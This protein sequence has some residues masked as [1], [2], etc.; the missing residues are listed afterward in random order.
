MS[1]GSPRTVLSPDGTFQTGQTDAVGRF[2]VAC[3]S[4]YESRS[5]FLPGEAVDFVPPNCYHKGSMKA[6][7]WCGGAAFQE[8][9]P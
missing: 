3:V 5:R 6:A 7:G 1:G 9:I 2:C 8:G 4:Y